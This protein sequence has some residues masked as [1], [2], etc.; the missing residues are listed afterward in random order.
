[1]T[2][3]PTELER[4]TAYMRALAQQLVH[5]IQLLPGLQ[6]MDAGLGKSEEASGMAAATSE[7]LLQAR[8]L[9]FASRRAE[10]LST[11]QAETFRKLFGDTVEVVDACRMERVARDVEKAL[12]R[13]LPDLAEEVMAGMQELIVVHFPDGL[14][15]A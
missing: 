12:P 13:S 14:L 15:G 4:L 2:N 7:M 10:A 6:A 11:Q 3:L 1:M 5:T 8:A 9:D